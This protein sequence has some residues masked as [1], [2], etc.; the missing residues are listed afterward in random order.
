MYQRIL[1]GVSCV[2]LF[3]AMAMAQSANRMG[4]DNDF[5]TKAARGGMAEVELGK[6]AQQNGS[7]QKVKDFG[8]RMVDDHS[9]A[10]QELSSIASKKGV[11]MPT[12][13]DAKD[14]ATKDRLSKL[15]GAAFDRAYMQDMVKD[16]RTDVA[17]FKKEA[18]SGTD[19][20]VK[21]F[22]SKTLPTLEDH[23]KLA[24]STVSEI[25]K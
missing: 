11:T 5:V 20:D 19:N 24:E 7:D 25:K 8:R 15:S 3:G 9:K 4:M 1:I 12:S 16:H 14:Q 6:L 23:L 17:E 2:A 13:L 18:N 21:Q 10:N 22:A